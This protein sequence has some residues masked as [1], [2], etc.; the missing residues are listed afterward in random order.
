V[1]AFL[2]HGAQ[3]TINRHTAEMSDLHIKLI[4]EQQ[5]TERQMNII[6]RYGEKIRDLHKERKVSAL[7]CLILG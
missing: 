2:T 3:M 5:K 4:Y 7:G 1:S 6:E